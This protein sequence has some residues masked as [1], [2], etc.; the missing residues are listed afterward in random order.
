MQPVWIGLALLGA[1][2]VA[3]A[4]RYLFR[5]K[6]SPEELERRR[7]TLIHE[8]GKLGDGEIVDV[9]GHLIVYSYAVAGVNYTVSQ[10]ASSLE[11]LMPADRMSLVGPV[12]IKYVPRNPANSIV[13]AEQWHG[14][15]HPQSR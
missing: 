4:A 11:A 10:D 14:L 15:R 12:L 9:D 2:A 13:M 7:R 5:S 6:P 3:F 1:G 8:T